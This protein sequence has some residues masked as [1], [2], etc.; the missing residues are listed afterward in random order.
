M[1]VTVSQQWEC[2]NTPEL[3]KFYVMCIL[4]RLQELVQIAQG[5]PECGSLRLSCSLSQVSPPVFPSVYARLS[6]C[7]LACALM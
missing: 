2:T 5:L 4:T 6:S 1:V 3:A 7:P